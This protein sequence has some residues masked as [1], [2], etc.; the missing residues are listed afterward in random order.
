VACHRIEH[1]FE[2]VARP[3]AS[4]AVALDGVD[5]TTLDEQQLREFV[6]A[7]DQMVSWAQGLQAQGIAEIARRTGE[8]QTERGLGLPAVNFLHDPFRFVADEVATELSISQSA[9]SHRV[10]FATSLQS[11]PLTHAALI[12]GRVDRSKADLIVDLLGQVESDA[13]V[14]LLEQAALD[15]AQTHTRPQLRAWLRRRIMAVEP[16]H[17]ERRRKAARA[18]RRVQLFPGDDGMST[19]YAELPSEDALAIYLT[20]D[21]IAH[22]SCAGSVTELRDAAS[23]EQPVPRVTPDGRSLNQR[24]ADAF[25]DLLLSRTTTDASIDKTIAV[26]EVQVVVPL[27]TLAGLSKEPGELVGYGPI[28]AEHARSL[29]EGDCRW[30]RLLSDPS[31]SVVEVAPQTYRPGKALERLVKARDLVCRFPGCRRSA[32]STSTGTP[33]RVDLDHTVPFPEGPTVAENL[34]ALCRSHHLLKTHSEWRVRQDKGGTLT[35]TTPSGRTFRTHAHAY[36]TA[37]RPAPRS[38]APPDGQAA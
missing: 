38:G 7:A 6:R 31:G 5:A 18:E 17:A 20:I 26:S 33:N 16:E 32:I 27:E 21:Q 14:E 34:A 10:C 29:A 8:T 36:E 4:M 15:Y 2:A 24:R 35:W 1:M 23:S 28:T 13:F 9:A 25:T 30:R 37:G 3:G 12:A 11:H 22:A 19:L